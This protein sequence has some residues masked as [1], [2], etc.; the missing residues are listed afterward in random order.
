MLFTIFERACALADFNKVDIAEMSREL[1]LPK[2]TSAVMVRNETTY[3]LKINLIKDK[4]AALDNLMATIDKFISSNA[5]IIAEASSVSAKAIGM[6]VNL[7]IS[8]LESQLKMLE[9]EALRIKA[10]TSAQFV[11]AYPL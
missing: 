3:I 6:R 7:E 8:V 11:A 2:P 4:Q 9:I 5:G 10:M 1:F